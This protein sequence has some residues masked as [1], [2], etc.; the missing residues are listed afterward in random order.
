MK[1]IFILRHA[2]SDWSNAALTDFD[3]PLARRGQ[4]DARRMGRILAHAKHP[5]DIII[6]SPAR[7]AKQTAEL[8]ANAIDFQDAIHWEDGLYPGSSASILAVLR[9]LSPSIN[10]VALVGHN[11]ALE[12]TVTALCHGG[13]VH[14]GNTV[15]LPTAGLVR[16]DVHVTDWGR[17]TPGDGVLRWFLIPKMVKVLGAL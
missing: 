5:P 8:V 15:R 14:S 2:K 17:L 6:V 1:T 10:R 3:R 9:N 4:K 12:N 7:R 11:P 16:I 13:S